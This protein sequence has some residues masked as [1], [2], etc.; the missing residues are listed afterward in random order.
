[1]HWGTSVYWYL[2]V[3]FFLGDTLSISEA[4]CSTKNNYLYGHIQHYHATHFC[5][6]S[7]IEFGSCFVPGKV[8]YWYGLLSFRGKNI[9]KH[10]KK[11]SW[12]S[13][14]EPITWYPCLKPYHFTRHLNRQE[15]DMPW[16]SSNFSILGMLVWFYWRHHTCLRS[17]SILDNLVSGL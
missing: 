1:M 7:P 11:N 5:D 3:V 2:F 16:N 13:E 8:I 15:L 4:W 9:G 14:A 17:C 12:A 6:S 10:I